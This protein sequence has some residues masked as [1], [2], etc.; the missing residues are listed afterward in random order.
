MIQ[1]DLL[2]RIKAAGAAGV[3]RATLCAELKI[4][5]TL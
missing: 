4:K 3:T 2:A 5:D 1:P